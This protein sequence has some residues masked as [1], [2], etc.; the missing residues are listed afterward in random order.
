MGE[1]DSTESSPVASREPVDPGRLTSRDF[2]YPFDEDLIAQRPLSAR[3]ASRLLVIRRADSGMADRSFTDLPEL[4]SPGDVLVLN[5]TRVFPAR[6]VG[7]KPTGAAA[8]ILLVE[9]LDVDG[10][11]WRAL[12]RPG[13]KLKPGR[14]VDIAEELAVEIEDSAEG[15]G[16]IVRLV[17][18]LPCSDAL[19]RYGRVPLP[20]Y[21]RRPA[22]ASDR[23][24][25]QT[26]YADEVGSVAAPTAGLHFTH[27]VLDSIAARG[28]DIARITLHVGPGTFRPIECEDPA[29]HVIDAERYRVT[30]EAADLIN[31]ARRRGGKVWAAGTTAVRTLE[32]VAR[33][34]GSVVADAGKTSLFIRPG[35]RFKIV[36]RLIT[37]FHLPRSTL[38]MLVAAFAG[39]EL[40]LSAYRHAVDSGYRFY[41]YGDSMVVL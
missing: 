25:Y 26:V 31:A 16:R 38:L 27:A 14:R 1:R 29:D 2:D 24:R 19:E 15:S 11:R 39:Y 13:G 7:R 28:V 23:G 6:L 17:T 40:T 8:E 20:P 12:V 36:D 22:D 10:V 9:P 21:V 30:E 3:D 18:D 33:A 5:D 34:D 37:N 32:T 4:L 35:Y 41:S